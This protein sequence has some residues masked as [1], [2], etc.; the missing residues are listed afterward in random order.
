MKY[1]PD[2]MLV[3]HITIATLL[4]GILASVIAAEFPAYKKWADEILLP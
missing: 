1:L 4:G 2:P 3:L